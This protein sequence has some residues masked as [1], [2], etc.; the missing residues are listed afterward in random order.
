MSPYLLALLA[1][2]SFALGSVLQQKGTLQ[3]SAAE[4][5]PRF[6]AE[7]LRKPVWLIGGILQISGW[8]LQAA[9]LEGGSL[10]V[11]QSLCA[12]SLV[13]RS[14]AWSALHRPVYRQAIDHWCIC[15]PA[16]DHRV[17]GCRPT[18]GRHLTARSFRLVDLGDHHCSAD[19]R[20]SSHC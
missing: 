17:C 6:L 12:L 9:A 11:V 10:V 2:L 19:R 3:T 13:I 1:A 7:I 5:D 18:S 15:H 16:W 20:V 8:V 14:A 4:G